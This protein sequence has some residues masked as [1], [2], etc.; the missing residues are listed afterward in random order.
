VY[1]YSIKRIS[2]LSFYLLLSFSIFISTNASDNNSSKLTELDLAKR[3]A[4]DF[5]NLA[6][7]I[8]PSIVVIESVDRNGYEGGRGTGFVVREDGVIATNFHVIGEHR[9]FS[10]RFPDGK[11]FRPQSILAIDRN[12]DLALIKIEAQGLPILQLGDSRQITPGQSILSIG[13][14]LGY[15]H[16]VSR[17]VVAA[18]RELEFGDG[19][20]MVQVAIPIEPG[21][22]GSPALDL[23]GKV[24]AILS[25]KSGGAMGFGVP[26]NELKKLLGENQSSS[27]KKM[28][29]NRKLG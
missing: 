27:H 23:E 8:R 15:E 16:S 3:D 1:F 20:P 17:G 22:S 19:R 21:S 26:V 4:K 6:A 18:V 12:R 28:V 25:I 2:D 13:N 29:N 24:L 7:S 10:V 11:T 14:P 5:K 9:D